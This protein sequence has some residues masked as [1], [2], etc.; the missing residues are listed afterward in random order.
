M[1]GRTRTTR[2]EMSQV[3]EEGESRS[4]N[5]ELENNWSERE[6]RRGEKYHIRCPTK[7]FKAEQ[8]C[9]A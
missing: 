5:F 9:Q 6:Q 4:D 2:M 1:I 3:K 7:I 8:N